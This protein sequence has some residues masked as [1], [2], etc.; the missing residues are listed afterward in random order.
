M[1]L[2]QTEKFCTTKEAI[3]QN[4]KIFANDTSDKEFIAKVYKEPMKLNTKKK[5]D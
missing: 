5:S 4:K 1:G 3:K 2:H